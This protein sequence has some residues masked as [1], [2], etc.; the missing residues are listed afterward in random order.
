[1]THAAY[2]HRGAYPLIVTALLAAACRLITMRPGSET[3]G[4]RLI[5]AL[6]YLW[7][8]Q[9]IVLVIS[10]ILRLDLYVSIYSLTYWRVAAFIWMGLVAVGLVL[11]MARHR[12]WEIQRMA[13]CRQ[14]SDAFGDALCPA[15]SSTSLQ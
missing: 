5:R 3:S 6:V 14:S 8:A 2:A 13:L 9:N 7:T 15:A 1:M 10:S 12:A 11:I 4:D